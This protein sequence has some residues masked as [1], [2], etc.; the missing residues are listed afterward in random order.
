MPTHI[1]EGKEDRER[2]LVFG[3]HIF[4]IAFAILLSFLGILGGIYVQNSKHCTVGSQ[5]LPPY[6]TQRHL[7]PLSSTHYLAQTH[8]NVT[9]LVS[10]FIQH[11]LVSNIS[12]C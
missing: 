9:Q 11:S 4:E 7:K 1:W 6:Q 5:F 8:D 10:T 3:I 2:K 12:Y